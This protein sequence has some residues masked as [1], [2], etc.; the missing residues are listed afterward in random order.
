MQNAWMLIGNGRKLMDEIYDGT[1]ELGALLMGHERGAYWYGSQVTIEEARKLAPYNNATSIQVAAGVMGGVVW[2]MEHPRAGILDPDDIDFQRVLEV[3]NPYL[4][5]ILG[6]YSE[7]TPLH[8]R[9]HPFPEDVDTSDPW[10]FK[11][12]RVM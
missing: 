6:V 12:F 11:N 1:D 7:W 3:A 2:A 10:Q 8:E 9:N 4:G 5:K